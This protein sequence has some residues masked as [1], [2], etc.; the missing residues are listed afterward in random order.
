MS[1]AFNASVTATLSH[2]QTGQNTSLSLSRTGSSNDIRLQWPGNVLNIF[3]EAE[4][5]T[6]VINNG[7]AVTLSLELDESSEIIGRLTYNNRFYGN[8]KLVDGV[9]TVELPNRQEVS[10]Y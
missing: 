2:P 4:A 6:V 10:L 8:V 7:G 3:T 5:N 9:L 1:D